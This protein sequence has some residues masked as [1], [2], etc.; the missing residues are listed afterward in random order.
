MER[1]HGQLRA[2]L[3][4]RLGGDGA[5][6]QALLDEL[7]GRHVR[8][9][10]QRADAAGRVTG[11]RAADLHG[12]DAKRLDFAGNVLVNEQVLTDDRLVGDR[13]NDVVEAGTA[14][15]HV[16]QWDVD[17][18]TLVDGAFGDAALGPAIM[19]EHNHGLRDVVEFAGEIP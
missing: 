10:A 18:L 5:H 14:D 11:Q 15:D 6:G 2:R 19:K 4:D 17:F 9:V 13:V 1:P 8:A 7:P 12:V 3:A 16:P